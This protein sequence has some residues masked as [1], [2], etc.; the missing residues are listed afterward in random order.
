[1]SYINGGYEM[2]DD[3][4]K[5]LDPDKVGKN[6]TGRETRSSAGKRRQKDRKLF[7]GTK[8][9]KKDGGK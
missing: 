4:E 6:P 1:M 9:G 7:G 2:G 8:W 3:N 5:E